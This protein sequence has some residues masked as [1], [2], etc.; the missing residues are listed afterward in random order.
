VTRRQFLAGA[1]VL[2]TA[3]MASCSLG[4]PS[5][6]PGSDGTTPSAATAPEDPDELL[7]QAAVADMRAL[8]ASTTATTDT[9][10]S[11]DERVRPL[12]RVLN[13]QLTV[14]GA[15]QPDGRPT[16]R[17]TPSSKTRI[18]R[19]PGRALTVLRHDTSQAAAARLDD[20]LAAGSGPFARVLAAISAGLD[21]QA[22]RLGGPSR[23]ASVPPSGTVDPAEARRLQ[24]ALS[25]EHAAAYAY[26]VI[27]ARG[28][29][30]GLAS[31]RLGYAVHLERRD[32]L[33]SMI[34][35][36]GVPPAAALPGYDLPN[37]ITGPVAVAHFA[38]T[39]ELRC[40]EVYARSVSE[41]TAGARGFCA[42]ALTSC[43]N[44]SV[45]WGQAPQPFP[46]APEL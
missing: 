45:T 21:E 24:L 16:P 14:L 27:G 42:S 8:L 40:C 15:V 38:R 7:L 1:T 2:G 41:T 10:H 6:V 18:P 5:H 25:A 26:G 43:A 28:G 31:S 3:A 34:Q 19:D 11:L 17:T 37:R 29:G 20:T 32:V 12:A 36:S 13:R 44:W 33:M 22:V 39:V 9:H 35:A 23:L 30:Q 4:S 46:G